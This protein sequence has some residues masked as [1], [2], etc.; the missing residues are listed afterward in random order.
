MAGRGSNGVLTREGGS[1]RLIGGSRFLRDEGNDE[2]SGRGTTTGLGRCAWQGK[3][4]G[5]PADACGSSAC[6]GSTS[7][8]CGARTGGPEPASSCV[9]CGRATR[10]AR[11]R[12]MC[13]SRTGGWSLPCVMSD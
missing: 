7:R 12:T 3:A 8:G 13:G 1:G 9:Y 4:A 6:H 5:G 11:L 10:R 2:N